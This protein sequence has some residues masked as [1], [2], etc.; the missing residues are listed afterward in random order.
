MPHRQDARQFRRQGL[1]LF[2]ASGLSTGMGQIRIVPRPIHQG[3]Q[4]PGIAAVPLLRRPRG[5]LHRHAVK[6]VVIPSRMA[7]NQRLQLF[8]GGHGGFSWLK[9]SCGPQGEARLNCALFCWGEQ[10]FC[11]WI[12][13]L[14]SGCHATSDGS[15]PI[16]VGL[17]QLASDPKLRGGR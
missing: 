4:I 6:A 5:H 13:T 3:L 10:G 7:A 15:L 11:G 1:R 12:H 17:S 16:G 8:S 14:P 2:R 9:G